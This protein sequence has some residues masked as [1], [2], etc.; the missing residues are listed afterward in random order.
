M[1]VTKLVSAMGIAAALVWG[2]GGDGDSEATGGGGGQ[3]AGS[4][5]TGGG[6]GSAG[7]SGAG[8]SGSG[9]TAGTGGSACPSGVLC[10]S[11]PACCDDGQE[12]VEGEC[13]AACFSGVRCAGTCC[14]VGDL[15]LAGDCVAPGAACEDSFDC[16][17]GEFCEPTIGQCLPQPAQGPSCEYFPPAL[18][19][20]PL[21]EWSW[22]GSPI[23]PDYDQ[24]LSIPLVADLDGDSIPEVVIVTHDTGDGSCDSG[25][26]Y[27]RALDGR[28][29]TEK[30]DANVD[31]Y[32]DAA[33]VAFCRTPA[34]GDLD[35]DGLA[36]IIAARYGGGIL[37]LHGDGSLAWTSTQADGTTPY[38]A[39]FPWATAVA[40]AHVDSDGVP[41]VVAGGVVLDA[42]GKL[43]VGAGL[44]SF[45]RG[46][47][48]VADVDADGIQEV[49]SGN[50]AMRVDGTM[51]W[52]AGQADGY[53]AI[54]DLD[55]DGT[56]ELVV[57]S[58]GTARVHDA[59]TGSLLA[60]ADMPGVGNGGPPTVSDFDGDGVRDFASAVGDSYT[61]FR[62]SSQPT[63]A[64]E[65]IWSVPTLDISSSQTGSSVFDFEGDGSSEVLYNDE[66]Y[67]RVY[68]GTD[69]EVLFETASSSGTASLYPVAVDVDGDNNT[70][71][72]VAS[73]DKYQIA[74]IT[75][76][77][78]AYVAGQELR[79]GVF[80][81]GDAN[82]KWVRTRRVWNQHSYHIT[83]V[84]ADGTLPDPEPVS[85]GP[86]GFNSY[87][88]S[89]QGAGAYN[90]P[91]LV[92]DLSVLAT[93]CPQQVTLQARVTNQGSL[94]VS[95]G[96][97]VAFFLGASP[98]GDALGTSQTT[99][100]LLPG[101]SEV[102]SLMVQLGGEPQPWAFRVVVDG[103]SAADSVVDECRE[104]NNESAID[105]VMCPGVK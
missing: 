83:N 64:I 43:R 4:G 2:C 1:H 41:D 37:A 15:C 19:F 50:A 46:N 87:R 45:G 8:H 105:G 80:A 44:E 6:A 49:L 101:E 78:P 100:A 47:A 7:S 65:V 25:F 13:M 98:P 29:G 39:Y 5:G 51:L 84:G 71:L 12:C 68:G 103:T 97:G 91:D 89:S 69:G 36:E 56:P 63:P 85:W 58:A 77:C 52:Q 74:G 34:V 14:E 26:A 96:I 81:Y 59:T 18:P 35:G 72:L 61:I 40:V 30:W 76:G 93:G 3:D 73:D 32:T 16:A 66:C 38:S 70:E 9:G 27:V 21:L 79:H 67:L 62:Y 42:S 75:P 33:R 20:D 10:G 17:E 95:A 22:E 48:I 53:P 11:P 60:S 94:G 28:D 23:A 92:V 104:D 24:V 57:I 88:V 90:A 55:G 99:K 54:G 82:D 102:V 31:A 86:S